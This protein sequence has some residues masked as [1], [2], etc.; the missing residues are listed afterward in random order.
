MGRSTFETV[1]AALGLQ[2]IE[3]R[4]DLPV[5]DGPGQVPPAEIERYVS[6][7][8]V[9][10]TER[11]AVAL[12]DIVGFSKLDP[13]QQAS[14]LATLEFALNLAAETAAAH[15]LAAELVRSTTGDGFYVWSAAKGLEA[16][17]DLFALAILFVLFSAAMRRS[18]EVPAAAPEIRLCIGIGSHYTYRRAASGEPASSEFIVGEITITL[19][20]LM[21]AARPGQILVSDFCRA[22]DG[23]GAPVGPQSLLT[24]AVERL[25]F[26]SSLALLGHPIA[27][28]KVYLTGPKR[29]DAFA[30][31]RLRVTDKHGLAHDCFNLK[32]NVGLTDAEPHFCGL[33]HQDVMGA[34]P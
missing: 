30:V 11:R 19:A 34:R 27:G 8:A 13:A 26:V 14:Q 16:D 4:L 33:R 10:R 17:E 21:S 28:L 5:G 31:Q 22:R 9:T 32:V 1:R 7:Y 24:R 20:R 29:G 3:L 6:P 2:S 25:A 12:I 23:G 18:I 15:G